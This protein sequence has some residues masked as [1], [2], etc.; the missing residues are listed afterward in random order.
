MSDHDH[1][2]DH[3]RDHER[4]AVDRELR[5]LPSHDA[6]ERTAERVR[7]AAVDVFV[8]RHATRGRPLRAIASR[9]ARAVPALVVVG[10][11]GIYLT[12]AIS[13]ANALFGP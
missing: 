1:E 3:D 7:H 5:A 6:D 11:V 10:T 12:W 8:E 9:T 4:D 13:A 2:R